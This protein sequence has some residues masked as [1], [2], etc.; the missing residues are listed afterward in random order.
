MMLGAGSDQVN[1]STEP[2]ICRCQSVH[3]ALL[4][5]PNARVADGLTL[6]AICETIC[7]FIS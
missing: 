7:A 6:P 3:I 2:G 4:A 1:S 5:E